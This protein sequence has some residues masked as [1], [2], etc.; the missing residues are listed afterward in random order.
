MSIAIIIDL[1]IIA[2]I[3]LC[4]FIGYKQGLIKVAIKLVATIIA[5]ILSLVLYKPISAVIINNTT[6]DE[7]I[8]KTI[9]DK[10]LPDSA[11]DDEAASVDTNKISSII[12]NSTENTVKSVSE[13]ISIKIIE[14]VVL[15]ILYIA[16]KIALRIIALIADLIS[17]L[18]VLDQINKLRWYCLW[19]FRRF[20]YCFCSICCYF[21]SS[22]NDWR[23]VYGSN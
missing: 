3:A 18:P 23:R 22:S 10:L 14:L 21:I 2:I 11:S 1:I 19:C 13:A 5:I 8:Q 15:I 7:Q 4:T 17:K 16:I 12:V 9:Q 6:F 20:P